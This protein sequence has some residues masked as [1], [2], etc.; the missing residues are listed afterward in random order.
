ML[1][2]K[3]PIISKFAK[4]AAETKS[5]ETQVLPASFL[6]LILVVPVGLFSNLFIEDLKKL[7]D[8]FQLLTCN[9]TSVIKPVF[10]IHLL[11]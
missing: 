11:M 3:I 1:L 5:E 2:P 7:V 9:H 8:V 10:N 6:A 4:I